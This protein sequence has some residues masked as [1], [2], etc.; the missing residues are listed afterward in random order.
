MKNYL[1]E[2]K[3]RWNGV[4]NPF[5]VH[6]NTKLSF[7]D[8]TNEKPIDLSDIKSGDVV[9]LIGDFNPSSILTLLQLIVRLFCISYKHL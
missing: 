5:F 8:I 1:K 4:N 9:A 3:K 6:L 2:L 7:Q